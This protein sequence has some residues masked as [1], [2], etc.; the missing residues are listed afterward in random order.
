RPEARNALDAD[1][2]NELN[3]A[4]DEAE[5]NEAVKIVVIQGAGDKVFAAGAD[6]KQLN[7]REPLGALVP[8]M[9]GIYNKL[10]DCSKVTIAAV[11]GFAL[12]GGCELAL[13]VISVLQPT[14]QN[15]DY[16]N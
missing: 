14:K 9:Q 6:I 10:E 4:I 2:L 13:L 8:G 15:L 12:G 5:S 1:T 11:H 16:R 3:Q 7:E